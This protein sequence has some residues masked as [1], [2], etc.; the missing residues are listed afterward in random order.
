MDLK[1]ETQPSVQQAGSSDDPPSVAWAS[2]FAQ[3]APSIKVPVPGP[4][5]LEMYE[6][7]RAREFGHFQWV[8]MA[9]VGFVEGRGVTLEDCDG[10]IF[11]D[12]THGHMGAS[13]GH[14]NPEVIAAVDKQIRRVMHLRNNPNDVRAEL[15]EKLATIT[16]GDL[17]RFA[18]YSSGT[19]AAEGAM[20]VAR[21]ITGGHEFIS[22]YGD[23]HGRTTGAMSTAWGSVMS[24][25]R[26]GGFHTFPNAWCHRCEFGLQP[27]SC[28]LHCVDYL[29]RA[30]HSNSHGQLAG[31]IAEP[32]TNGSGARVFPDGYLRGLREMADR[33][34]CLLIFDEHATGLGRTGAMWAGDHE[35]VVPDVIFFGKTLGNG[36]PVTVVACREEYHEKLN[37]DGQSSTHGGQPVA[38]AAALAS[39]DIILRDDL[40]AHCATTGAAALAFMQGIAE[41]HPCVDVAQGRGMQLAF[42]FVDP[43]TKQPSPAVAEAVFKECTRRGVWPSVVHTTIRVSPMMVTS[44]KIALK[45]MGIVEEAIAHV[46]S[47]Y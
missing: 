32:I 9:Q 27:D 38:C 12:I 28:N 15:M 37:T 22:F 14:A 31:I 42:E 45:I 44:E 46:E 25:P 47:D 10:N 6:R 39:L 34:G 8:E 26:L 29:E 23:Y 13:L 1:V 3:D 40:T 24:G 36:Y 2:A 7:C 30:I 20:R 43:V 35:G 21:A 11:I 18:F 41:R 33:L 5:S 16:P 17:N 4:K 19:E